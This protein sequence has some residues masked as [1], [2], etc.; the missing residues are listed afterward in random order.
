MGS[1][2]WLGQADNP[3]TDTITWNEQTLKKG[4]AFETD[5]MGLLA[6]AAKTPKFFAV[7][8]FEPGPE[9]KGKPVIGAY[10]PATKG[11]PASTPT[12]YP[13]VT[14]ISAQHPIAQGGAPIYSEENERPPPPENPPVLD[15][16]LPP[17]GESAVAA[18]AKREAAKKPYFPPPPPPKRK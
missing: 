10:I 4:E 6:Q 2:K 11:N 16:T 8:G 17:E 1:I 13:S 14:D 12:V 9:P 3:D 7:T 5:N 15:N 18:A